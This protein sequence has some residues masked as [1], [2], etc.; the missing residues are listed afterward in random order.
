LRFASSTSLT[1]SDGSI[2]AIEVVPDNLSVMTQLG[3]VRL[4]E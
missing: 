1:I 4:A 3:A 2:N